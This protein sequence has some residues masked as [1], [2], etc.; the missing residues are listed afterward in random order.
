MVELQNTWEGRSLKNLPEPKPRKRGKTPTPA[1][2]AAVKFAALKQALEKLETMP[3]P[4]GFI[5]R[6]DA[7]LVAVAKHRLEVLDYEKTLN[8]WAAWIQKSLHNFEAEAH[9]LSF[10]A[11]YERS[12]E[13]G[14]EPPDAWIAAQRADWRE[15][16]EALEENGG[17]AGDAPPE[18]ISGADNG[19]N[20]SA[21]DRDA[22][23]RFLEFVWRGGVADG[24]IARVNNGV[25][26]FL[27]LSYLCSAS[28]L[29]DFD[30][31]KLADVKFGAGRS[32][33]NAEVARWGRVLNVRVPHARNKYKQEEAA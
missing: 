23:T 20:F 32:K 26:S 17:G 12:Q 24:K 33:Y 10:D 27:A 31:R 3:K 18:K 16:G 25:V 13:S 2:V 9:S 14:G 8:D 15:A 4:H 22:I 21:A 6:L 29:Q 7:E 30:Y 1:E 5:P 11:L 19:F 28:F